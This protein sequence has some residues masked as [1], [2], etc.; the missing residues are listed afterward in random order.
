MWTNKEFLEGLKVG[1]TVGISHGGVSGR[2]ST[3]RVER[4]TKTQIVVGSGLREVKYNRTTGHIVGDRGWHGSWMVPPDSPDLLQ[5]F[6]IHEV[7][8][9]LSRIDTAVRRH[10]DR[11]W[12][13]SGE[14]CTLLSSA[15]ELLEKEPEKQEEENG[16]DD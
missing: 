1:D 11:W 4:L 3:T 13:N 2:Y 12:K 8:Q 15:I 9:R 14:I 7:E 16:N 5:Y 10:K 6:A